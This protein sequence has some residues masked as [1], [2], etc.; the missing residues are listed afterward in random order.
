MSGITEPHDHVVGVLVQVAESLGSVGQ[1]SG[2]LMVAHF[3]KGIVASWLNAV[4]AVEREHFAALRNCL[5]LCV[6]DVVFHSQA[7]PGGVAFE[8]INNCELRSLLLTIHWKGKRL[9]SNKGRLGITPLKDQQQDA[10]ALWQFADLKGALGLCSP[11]D[12]VQ[13]V[14]GLNVSLRVRAMAVAD[15]RNIAFQFKFLAVLAD[16]CRLLVWVGI[17]DKEALPEL[18]RLH[19]RVVDSLGI[20]AGAE[21]LA[22]QTLGDISSRGK[23]NGGHKNQTGSLELHFELDARRWL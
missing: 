14:V 11:Q 2:L 3:N 17:A 1:E 20:L 19:D 4:H 8:G 12:K 23:A 15:L 5:V 18:Q 7:R 22:H 16:N 10:V 9:E 21:R 6:L 13:L